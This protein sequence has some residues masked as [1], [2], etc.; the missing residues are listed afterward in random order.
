MDVKETDKEIHI[1]AELPG[2]DE[3]DIDVSLSQNTLTIKGEKKSEV[4]DNKEGYHRVER[5]YGSF[6]RSIPLPC[7]VNDEK[8]AAHFKKGVLTVQLPKT[9]QA[10]KVRKIIHITV[11]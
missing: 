8:I 9:P 4:E 11:S 2:I 3:K 6:H 5:R 1:I 7:E 10:Q